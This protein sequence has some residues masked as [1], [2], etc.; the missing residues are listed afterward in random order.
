MIRI[1]VSGG[2]TGGHI[3][4]A[5]SIA[6]AL[7]RL[8]GEIEI[9]FVGAEGKMEMEKVPE[10]G[11]PIEGL[12]V[13]GLQRRLTWQNVKVLVNLCRSLRK[14]RKIIKQFRPDVVVGVGGYASG[15]IGRVAS[16]MGVPLVLQEQI[17]YA[18]VSNKLLANIAKK[19]CVA[20]EGMVRFFDRE[21]IVFTGNPVRKDLLQAGESRQ[22][23]FAYYKLDPKK[24]TVLVTGG[25][26]GAGMINKAI[27]ENLSVI[28]NWK[29][30]QVLWQCGG[31]YYEQLERELRDKLPA[32]VVLTAFLKRMDLAYACADIVVARAGA[33]T[34]SELCL[35]KKT[36][37][38]IPSPNVA[39]DHQTKNAMALVNKKA[40]IAIKDAEVAD[41]LMPV[42][43][44]LLE[45]EQ[46][47]KDLSV[48][49]AQLAIEDSDIKIAEEILKLV[50]E[51]RK[52]V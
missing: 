38:L 2:G 20:Y 3:F 42:L 8:D 43:S 52:K 36:A 32:N 28:G 35:L 44:E 16:R 40:A 23:G 11:F 17:S 25:S 34:I 30:V 41:R 51:K 4:P 47:R 21:K 29:N 50:R 7:K 9:L 15:P 10:A 37:V 49:I 45:S 39:E 33:G 46:K 31:Y 14:A 5:L 26:L 22:E 48:N 6:N 1:I 18:G 12:P 19:L 27:R 24:K 13:R